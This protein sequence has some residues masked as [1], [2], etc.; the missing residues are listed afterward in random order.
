M[1]RLD[2]TGEPRSP[3]Q[4]PDDLIQPFQIEGRAVRGRLV[5]L[6]PL[7][8]E[9]LHRHAYPD[10]VAALLAEMVALAAV[11]SAALKFEGVFSLQ[12]KGDGAIRL[13]VADVTSAGDVRGYAQFDDEQLAAASADPAT[14]SAPVPHLLGSGYLAFTVDQ[15][16]HTER[17]QGIVE[18]SG[19]TLVDCVHHYFRQSEQLQADIKL[20][21]GR[22]A[23][24]D[25][26]GLGWRAGALMVQRM[27]PAGAPATVAEEA[28]ED[29]RRA[30]ALTA[31]STPGELLDP[32]LAPNDL[33]YR[34]FHEDGVRV[35][36][37]GTLRAAC[38][39]SRERVERVLRSMPRGEIETLKVDGAVVVTCE[40]C[41]D[42]Y[43]FSDEDLD[44][45]Y[46]TS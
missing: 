5:R 16:P 39:C 10:P 31:S 8:D 11:L 20:A 41:N 13:M 14:A 23:R 42:S 35:F 18:L 43:R 37:P 4:P 29:W 33:L 12:T 30:L 6:G 22:E 44:R 2:F 26:G 17:Y 1:A 15:G 21:V 27:P 36:A 3:R 38:R 25:G 46:R 24:T 34:L 32:A 40:F 28:E 45:L 7:V 9:I 19:G